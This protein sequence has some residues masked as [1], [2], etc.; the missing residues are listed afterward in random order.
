MELW[1]GR[2]GQAEGKDEGGKRSIKHVK[3][4][5]KKKS[6]FGLKTAAAG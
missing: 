3:K 2:T 4:K 1:R 6:K 5:K